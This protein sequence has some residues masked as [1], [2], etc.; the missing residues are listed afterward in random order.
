[1]K[2]LVTVKRKDLEKE[3]CKNRRIK[4]RR[5]VRMEGLIEREL[6]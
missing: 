1:V 5:T 2:D 6:S 4:R 3:N